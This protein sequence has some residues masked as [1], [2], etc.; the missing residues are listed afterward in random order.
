MFRRFR[1][2]RAATDPILVIAAITVSLVLL[3]GGT[4]TYKGAIQKAQDTKAKTSLSNIALAEAAT[5]NATGSYSSV[6]TSLTLDGSK[7][8]ATGPA[9]KIYTG[10]G[11][12]AAF[13]VSDAGNWFYIS[14]KTG[15]ASR[16]AMPWPSGAPADYP[17]SCQWPATQL[18]ATAP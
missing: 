13:D 1:R 10:T 7:P 6:P 9:T 2:D 5:I 15:S 12:F 17:A 4:V 18:P 3:G 14:S 8:V 11:C 16:V